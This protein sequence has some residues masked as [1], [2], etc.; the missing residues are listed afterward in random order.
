M[1]QFCKMTI[2]IWDAVL[3]VYR[4]DPD[5]DLDDFESAAEMVEFEGLD[6]AVPI[7]FR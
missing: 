4:Q 7:Y 5:S 3:T 1:R 6:K 2:D